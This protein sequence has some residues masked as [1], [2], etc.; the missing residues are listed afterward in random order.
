MKLDEIHLERFEAKIERIPFSTCWHWVG[1]KH[2]N[3]YGAF[4][5]YGH[6]ER[7]HRVSYNHFVGEISENLQIDHLCRNKACVNPAHLEPVTAQENSRRNPNHSS[8]SEANKTK[9]PSGHEYTSSNTYNYRG[10]RRCKECKKTH[11]RNFMQRNPDYK[12]L[13]K[14][15]NFPTL[16]K[17]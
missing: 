9:C 15:D 8:K 16:A 13:R 4:Q 7:A 2:Q 5:C 17:K 1:A 14:T 10:S 6:Q 11:F 3:G 12:M